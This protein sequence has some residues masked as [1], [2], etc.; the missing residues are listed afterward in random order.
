VHHL[1][2]V[3]STLVTNPVAAGLA[4]RLGSDGLEDILDVWPGLLVTTGH[5]GRTVTSTLLTTRDTS[6]NEAKTLL[7]EVLGAAVGVGIV[8]VT[9]VDDNVAGIAVGEELLNEVVDSRASHDKQHH[10][11][12]PLELGTELLDGVGSDNGL[13]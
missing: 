1:D 10:T 13:A 12:R 5:D 8:R 7:F 4:I 2:V 9:T 11:A 6:T 3:A